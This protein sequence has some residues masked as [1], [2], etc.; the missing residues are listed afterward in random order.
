MNLHKIEFEMKHHPGL[1]P[2]FVPIQKFNTA[3]LKTASIPFSVALERQDCEISTKATFIHDTDEFFEADWHYIERLVKTL[4]WQK[5]G[6]RIFVKGSE[7]IFKC[8]KEAYSPDGLRSFDAELMSRLYR[9]NFE[10]IRCDTLPSPKESAKSLG[11]NFSGNRI[12]FDAGGSDYKV[13]AMINGETVY[14]N[15]VV[16]SPKTNSDP[17]Y[18][19]SNIVTGLKSAMSHMPNVD[20]IGISSAGIVANNH[21]LYA[22]LFGKVSPEDFNSKCRD[23]YIRAVNEIGSNIP[24]ELANDGDVAALAGSISLNRNN[25]LGVAMGTS[26]A[27]GFVNEDGN[28][29]DWLNEIAFIPVDLSPTAALETWTGDFG[30]PEQYF[31]QNA[32]VRLADA[33]GISLDSHKTPAE[34]LKAVQALLE[35]GHE[36]ADSIFRT[37]GCYLGYSSAYF[38]DIYGATSILILGRVM[39][40]KG[41]NIILEKA[42]EVLADEYPDIQLELVLPDEKTRRLGQSVIAASLPKI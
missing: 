22:H 18:H 11:R 15:E 40:G 9:S 17:E 1:D 8:L 6:F 24:F 38:H 16:W 31:C 23:I 2:G 10:V 21:I 25:L 41:G 3:F 28:I 42:L 39:S 4:L 32:V 19:F 37:I 26:F 5:G 34:K 14:T 27:G 20:A 13:A 7:R 29:M 30:V 35:D 12:G 33:A 36:G